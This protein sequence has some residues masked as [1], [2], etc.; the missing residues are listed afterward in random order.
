[1]NWNETLKR[2]KVGQIV[3]ANIEKI[4][5]AGIHCKI[6]GGVQGYA[7]RAEAALTRRVVN[8]HQ[9][10]Q[11]NQLI[12]ARITGFNQKYNTIDLSIRQAAKQPWDDFV[13]KVKVGDFIEGQVVL[14]TESKALVEIKPGVTGLLPRQEMWMH[15]ET[16]DQIL[17]VDDRVRLQIVKIDESQKMLHLSAR[18]LFADEKDVQQ[19]NATFK[20]EEKLNKALDILMKG[21]R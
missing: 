12:Q 5:H 7:R 21:K 3:T 18:G 16:V 8:L 15:A 2:Y 13:G 10:F 19:R 11:P 14:L 1:M 17:M 20:I 4:D 9:L 6:D